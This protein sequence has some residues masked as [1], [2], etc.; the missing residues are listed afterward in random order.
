MGKTTPSHE[1]ANRG[2]SRVIDA[3]AE[4]MLL[5]DTSLDHNGNMTFQQMMPQ[6]VKRDGSTVEKLADVI[7]DGATVLRFRH[8]AHPDPIMVTQYESSRMENASHVL[9]KVSLV[10]WFTPYVNEVLMIC[11]S[12]D[13]CATRNHLI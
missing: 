8:N 11:Y 4:E 10:N 5:F 7:P 9:W 13:R 6:I 3:I 1:G 2:L 12:W